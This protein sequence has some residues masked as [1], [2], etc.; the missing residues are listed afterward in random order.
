[1][2]SAYSGLLFNQNKWGPGDGEGDYQSDGTAI[3][4]VLV[5]T[6]AYKVGLSEEAK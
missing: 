1:M 3:Y 4:T 6:L 2:S 5:V